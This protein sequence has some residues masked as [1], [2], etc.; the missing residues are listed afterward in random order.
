MVSTEQGLLSELPLM[1]SEA[2]HPYASATPSPSSSPSSGI[3]TKTRPQRPA[4]VTS[5]S[6]FLE[7]T[8]PTSGFSASRSPSPIT[9]ARASVINTSPLPS[10]AANGNLRE[11]NNMSLGRDEK[12][13]RRR[14]LMGT[15]SLRVAHAALDAL[16]R[17]PESACP[18]A[19]YDKL[20]RDAFYC[21]STL[22]SD[23]IP[24]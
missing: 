10:A 6:S 4:V 22:G 21:R 9:F 7:A 16:L 15:E 5:S 13:D 24:C 11:K 20:E 14:R 1:A 23:I 19:V 8:S 12:K 3:K 17:V 18:R 2:A